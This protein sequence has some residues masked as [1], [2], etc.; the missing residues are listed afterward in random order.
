[1]ANSLPKLS[2]PTAINILFLLNYC[3]PAFAV[4]ETLAVYA[5]VLKKESVLSERESSGAG[6]PAASPRLPLPDS[7]GDSGRS[8]A[9]KPDGGGK[10]KVA[11]VS[12]SWR[13]PSARAAAASV[14]LIVPE[15]L[16]PVKSKSKTAVRSRSCAGTWNGTTD[17][18][19]D[20]SSSTKHRSSPASW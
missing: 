16:K 15:R 19:A 13:S 3:T 10:K 4:F 12:W 7:T 2:E 6:S 20:S 14:A 18:R 1:M 9:V 8:T 5:V 17:R 11:S